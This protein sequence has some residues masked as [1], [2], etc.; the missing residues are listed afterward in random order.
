MQQTQ[1]QQLMTTTPTGEKPQDWVEAERIHVEHGSLFVDPY[2]VIHPREL[3]PAQEP[4]LRKKLELTY[5]ITNP[6]FF[7]APERTA[8]ALNLGQLVPVSLTS[9][10]SKLLDEVKKFNAQVD[11]G[12]DS[13][14]QQ[15]ADDQRNP[16]AAVV[17]DVTDHPE[18]DPV[19]V[20]VLKNGLAIYMLIRQKL[21]QNHY[22]AKLP[23]YVT[24]SNTPDQIL[25]DLADN[26]G[27][28]PQQVREA[29]LTDGL[30]G[31]GK[32]LGLEP[33]YVSDV[34]Q[35]V[36]RSAAQDFGYNMVEHWHIGRQLL[37]PDASMDEKIA[38][39]MQKRIDF[40][41][42]EYRQ[43]V[44]HY[45]DVPDP[46]KDEE[47]RIAN[48]DMAVL[49]PIQKKLMF[50]LG[51]E[52][53][54]TSE[55]TADNI[56]FHKGIYG[57]HRKSAND[58]KDIDGTY[59]IYY[60]GH[61]SRKGS[62]GTLAHEVAHN[63]WPNYFDA[64]QVAQI[65]KLLNDDAARFSNLQRLMN[66]DFE[67]FEKLWEAYRAG[68]AKEKAA[69]I[70]TANERYATYGITVDGL[71]PTLQSAKDFR[72]LVWDAGD[73]LTTSGGRYERSGYDTPQERFREI[74]S[75]YAEMRQVSHEHESEVLKFVAPGLT[76]IWQDLYI[77]H[78]ERVYEDV[79]AH[80]QGTSTRASASAST[81]RPARDEAPTLQEQPK[82]DERIEI[83]APTIT[84]VAEPLPK[85]DEQPISPVPQIPSDGAAVKKPAAE[86]AE[87]GVPGTVVL[88]NTMTP[89]RMAAASALHN[90]GVSI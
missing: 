31:V 76:S 85:V 79:I 4:Q 62:V 50:A 56:A 80:R 9:A 36:E 64:P 71:F 59:R 19:G 44:R 72:Y 57:L 48:D 27:V 78:L 21:T 83:G 29:A 49:E 46:V 81:A 32:L 26:I 60:A 65:D 58:L 77:P 13:A 14:L 88:Q 28:S 17:R 11:S 66:K 38:A 8:I 52:I 51:Y 89:Q 54:H 39:G 43:K 2:L 5:G 6:S 12:V 33:A 7:E 70:A 74:I 22:L 34:K 23:D 69:V 68:D 82:V 90:M 20:E 3:D 63:F 40:K 30:E 41:I 24:R 25:H 73:V 18:S 55:T 42:Q 47:R 67:G 84:K 37:G 45:Y 61:G 10:R 75:R 87:Q 15:Q 86:R 1:A 53:C 35:L 16:F